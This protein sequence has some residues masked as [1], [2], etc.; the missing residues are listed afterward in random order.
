MLV[1]VLLSSIGNLPDEVTDVSFAD[2]LRILRAAPTALFAV[3][4]A[5]YF[6]QTILSLL[7]VYGLEMGL[8]A[9]LAAATLVV[10]LLGNVILQLP[11][12]WLSDRSSRRFT[13]LLLAA[14]TVVGG[15]WL[16]VAEFGSG[17]TW[18]FFFWGASGFGV[19]TVSLAALGDRHTKEMLLAGSS[20][21][22]LVCGIAGA[23]GPPV[24]EI[25]MD[26][27]GAEVLPVVVGLPYVGLLLLAFRRRP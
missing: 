16:G 15:G 8:T 20:A 14:F 24:S 6:D 13:M 3:G 27:L 1:V 18:M 17:Y 10:A 7:P 12:G 21:F 19:Y 2:F 22:A 4:C 9:R 23:V 11:I 25:A 26:R 5:A